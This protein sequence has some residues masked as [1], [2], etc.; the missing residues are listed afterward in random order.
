[1]LTKLKSLKSNILPSK[2]NGLFL[3]IFVAA[4]IFSIGLIYTHPDRQVDVAVAVFG[5]FLAAWAGGWAAFAA[6]RRTHDDAERAARISAANRALF[7]IATMFNVFDNLRQFSIDHEGMRQRNDRAF[8]M[9][10]PL[11]GMMQSLHFDFDSLS[12]FLD[13]N[14][15]LCSMV[16]IELQVL[17][18]HH[19][20]IVNTAV[21]R[22]EAHDDL[23]KA[24]FSKSIPNLTHES[25]QTVFRVEYSK[26]AALTDQFIIQW[27]MA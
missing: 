13:Q 19:Q 11:A 1:M 21:L 27:T 7:K 15:E 18:W 8:M 10:S 17:D 26:L 5:T 24:V 4:V 16:L 23:R 9:D 14:G 6:E 20:N 12:Y 2:F 3:A 25:M 22:T